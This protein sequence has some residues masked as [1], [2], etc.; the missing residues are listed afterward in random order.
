MTAEKLDLDDELVEVWTNFISELRNGH[1]R[2]KEEQ[3]EI[4]C[5]RNQSRHLI[6]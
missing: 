4:M 1:I 2:L 3:D 6:S 5:S